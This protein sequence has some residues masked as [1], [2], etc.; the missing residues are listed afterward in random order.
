MATYDGPRL[1][2]IDSVDDI[3]KM[4]VQDEYCGSDD[5]MFDDQPSEDE[6][7]RRLVGTKHKIDNPILKKED[8]ALVST[9]R[10]LAG[11]KRIVNVRPN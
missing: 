1:E 7:L 5:D 2:S 3:D 10:H 4:D 6:L 9:H 8:R 11:A